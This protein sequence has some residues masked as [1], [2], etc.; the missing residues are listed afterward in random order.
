MI[1][2][3]TFSQRDFERNLTEVIAKWSFVDVKDLQKWKK[4]SVLDI[5]CRAYVGVSIAASGIMGIIYSHWTNLIP[6]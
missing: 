4:G 2:F 1:Q 3:T 5:Y 6:F